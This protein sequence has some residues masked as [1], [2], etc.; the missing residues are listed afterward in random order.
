MR[1]S[2]QPAC[3]DAASTYN[4]TVAPV[5]GGTGY[6]WIASCV[7]DVYSGK[8]WSCWVRGGRLALRADE[9]QLIS[10]VYRL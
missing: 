1:V 9:R 5:A 8:L 7:R 10:I 3:C 4:N 2:S 6:S